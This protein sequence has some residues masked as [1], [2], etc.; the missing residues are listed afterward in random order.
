MP[1]EPAEACEVGGGMCQVSRGPP[2]APTKGPVFPKP[3]LLYLLVS[4]R[5]EG[6]AK[7]PRTDLTPL[8]LNFW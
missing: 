8:V 1:G 3:A 5:L 4:V 6:C 7:A 2:V